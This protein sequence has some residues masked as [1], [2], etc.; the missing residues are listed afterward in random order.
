MLYKGYDMIPIQKIYKCKRDKG[1]YS[2][3][4]IPVKIKTELTYVNRMHKILNNIAFTCII[5][6][7]FN[8]GLKSHF[9]AK[10][11][12]PQWHVVHVVQVGKNQTLPTT[13]WQ[14]IWS[15]QEFSPTRTRASTHPS[16]HCQ[17]KSSTHPWVQPV[18]SPCPW[19]LQTPPP[20]VLSPCLAALAFAS[21]EFGHYG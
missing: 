3:K 17:F 15:S 16:T 21:V 7:K 4:T 13:P 11:I 9:S 18:C 6:I 19:W 2:V 14:N 5:R 1:D 10:A 8:F 12:S 20:A